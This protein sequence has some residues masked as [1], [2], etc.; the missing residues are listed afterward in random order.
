MTTSWETL[1][2]HAVG[3]LR[4]HGAAT[5]DRVVLLADNSPAFLAFTWGALRAGIVLPHAILPFTGRIV[6]RDTPRH[7]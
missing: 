1:A 5:G 7:T 6:L 4:A 3:A 2:C